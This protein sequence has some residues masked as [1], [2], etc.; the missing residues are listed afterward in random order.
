METNNL[1]AWPIL[2]NRSRKQDISEYAS[3]LVILH[4]FRSYPIVMFSYQ[5]CVLGGNGC[6]PL[7]PM[8][9]VRLS[10]YSSHYESLS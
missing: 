8:L 5:C 4:I 1:L 7:L 10:C 2:T 9:V 6:V 3:Y